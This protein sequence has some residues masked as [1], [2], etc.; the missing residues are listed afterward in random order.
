VQFDTLHFLKELADLSGLSTHE[1]A[2]RDRI[3]REWEPLVDEIVISR[4]GNLHGIKYGSASSPRPRV[5]IMAQMDAI[6]MMVS[7][8]VDG[9]LRL[10]GAD[11]LDPYVLL[12]LPVIVHGRRKLQGTIVRAPGAHIA[13]TAKE[14][15]LTLGHLLVDVGLLPQEASRYVHP[16]DI[17]SFAWAPFQLGEDYL[18]GHSLSKRATAAATTVCLHELQRRSHLWDIVAVATRHEENGYG[19]ALTS[20]HLFHPDVVIT[21]GAASGQAPGLR[22]GQGYVLG[23][24]PTNGLGPTIHPGIYREIQRAAQREEIE[25]MDEIMIIRSRTDAE[26]L[27]IVREGIATGVINIPIRYL[28]TSIELVAL[29]DVRRTGRLLASFASGLESDF[30]ETLV[31]D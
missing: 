20:A 29:S 19:A 10:Q 11:G 9:F 1:D 31:W 23:K 26:G 12:G 18:A 14:S 17:V 6:R 28:H 25:L 13:S 5:L 24:G 8:I 27:Q 21:L 30:A 22:E 15:V 3:R 7:E 16:G 2:V 4:L